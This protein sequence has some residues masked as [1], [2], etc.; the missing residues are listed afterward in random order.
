MCSLSLMDYNHSAPMRQ[1]QLFSYLKPTNQRLIRLIR[2]INL[3]RP[4]IHHITTTTLNI[5]RPR[6]VILTI[7]LHTQII[8]ILT[9][10]PKISS[11]HHLIHHVVLIHRNPILR[12]QLKLLPRNTSRINPHQ[13][14]PHHLTQRHSL[15]TNPALFL[16]RSRTHLSNQ[17]TL[18]TLRNILQLTNI[19]RTPTKRKTTRQTNNN[20]QKRRSRSNNTT[21]NKRQHNY[22]PTFRLVNHTHPRGQR[23]NSVIRSAIAARRRGPPHR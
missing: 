2:T 10:T 14:R 1:N 17:L 11:R 3:Q 7:L 16:P 4:H 20:K 8:R 15:L 18:L 23:V 19:S 21:R 6:R 5:H 9:Q 22:S 13:L 12:I